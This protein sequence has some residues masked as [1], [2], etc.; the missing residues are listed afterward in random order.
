MIFPASPPPSLDDPDAIREHDWEAFLAVAQLEN[1]WDRAGWTPGRR[2]YHWFLT[3]DDEPALHDLARRCQQHLDLPQLDRIGISSLHLT[4][5]RIAFTDQIDRRQATSVAARARQRCAGIV[6]FDVEVGPLAGSAGAVR[7]SVAPWGE[8]TA[9]QRQL[10]GATHDVLGDL[11]VTDTSSFRPHVTI[12][13][14]NSAIEPREIHRRVRL[15]RELSPVRVRV[16]TACLVELR[17]DDQ[18]YGYEVIESVRLGVA[19][20]RCCAAPII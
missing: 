6:P 20:S 11:A 4:L 2:S 13:Y 18:A 8:L 3:F 1:H 7:F 14:A 12:A 5:G 17:R 15:T 9:L 10:T 16:S 19:T